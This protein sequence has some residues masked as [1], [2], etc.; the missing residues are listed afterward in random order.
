MADII[1]QKIGDLAQ[2][3]AKYIK[4]FQKFGLDFFCKGDLKLLEAISEA[5]VDLGEIM[6]FLYEVQQSPATGIE[7]NI[8]DWP[9]DLLSDYIQKTHHVY[10]EKTLTYLRQVVRE[11]L[12]KNLPEREIINNFQPYLEEI[13]GELGAHMKRE[14]LILF[15]TIKRIVMS[16]GKIENP[17][18]KTVQN[19]VDKM[20]HEHNTQFELLKK[21][22]K[23]LNHYQIFDTASKEFFDIV[24]NME[25]LDKDLGIHLHLENNLLFPCVVALEKSKIDN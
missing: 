23:I 11:F 7:V 22:R 15:P 17:G 24:K 1:E 20:I 21:I 18:A 13:A 6:P 4:I 16:R 8:G 9:L 19:P 25:D 2:N 12:E 3:N 14:E 5:E 10:T